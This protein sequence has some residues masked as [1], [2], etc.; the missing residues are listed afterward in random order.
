MDE[1]E[2][3]DAISTAY[4]F[5]RIWLDGVKYTLEDGGETAS[6]DEAIDEQLRRARR[7]D[8]EFFSTAPPRTRIARVAGHI[9]ASW[10]LRK[11][12]DGDPAARIKR[13]REVIDEAEAGLNAPSA[14]TVRRVVADIIDDRASEEDLAIFVQMG[15]DWPPRHAS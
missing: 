12:D 9:V 2:R 13:A 14:D 8:E 7:E 3:H 6:L 15:S 11:Q 1:I 10:A 5:A 4:N